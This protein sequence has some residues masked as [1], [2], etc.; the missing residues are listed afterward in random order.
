MVGKGG[1]KKEISFRVMGGEEENVRVKGEVD[2][3]EL[4]GMSIG[5]VG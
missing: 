2:D 3:V 4:R 1:K 5:A